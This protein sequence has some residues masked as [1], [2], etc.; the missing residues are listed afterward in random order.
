MSHNFR[1]IRSIFYLVVIGFFSIAIGGCVNDK[2]PDGPNLAAGDMLPEF[3]VVMNNGTLVSTSG[4]KG[5][6]SAII[7]F[8][9]GCFDCRRELPVVEKLWLAF[10]DSPEVEIIPISR[11]ETAEDIKSYWDENGFTMP[12]SAQENR[13]IYSKF[14]AS[15]IPRIYISN[16]SGVITSVYDDFDLPSLQTLTSALI[17]ASGQDLDHMIPKD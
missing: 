11:E 17:K 2:E 3:S 4:L 14:A 16:P 8:N 15:G 13:E 6:T 12:W 7:F 10:K 5:K 9:T 1:R